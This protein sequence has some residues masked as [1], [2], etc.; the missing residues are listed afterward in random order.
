MRADSTTTPILSIG[1]TI[2]DCIL[3]KLLVQRKC[4]GNWE[5]LTIYQRVCFL[6]SVFV[7]S[8]AK[9]ITHQR[10]KQLEKQ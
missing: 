8:E 4:L 9:R 2:L 5:C 7:F 3:S 6:G 10:Q 1:N